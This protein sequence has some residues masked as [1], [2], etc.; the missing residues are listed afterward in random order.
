M[1]LVNEQP[2]GDYHI[3]VYI[4]TTKRNVSSTYREST[5]ALCIYICGT[6]P[7][8]LLSRG[9]ARRA[10]SSMIFH[11]VL[12]AFLFSATISIRIPGLRSCREI[13]VAPGCKRARARAFSHFLVH[14]IVSF[15]C[16]SCRIARIVLVRSFSLPPLL[17]LFF[18]LRDRRCCE[19][20]SRCFIRGRERS[21]RSRYF[22]DI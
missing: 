18:S 22:G 9:C 8:Y 13:D 20:F 4:C 19:G 5:H 7:V 2:L 15:S 11:L 1:V 12:F 14:G 21:S 6:M 17:H 3:S 16:K 10:V